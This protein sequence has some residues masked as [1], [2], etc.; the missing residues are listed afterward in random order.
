MNQNK[1]HYDRFCLKRYFI[2]QNGCHQRKYAVAPSLNFISRPVSWLSRPVKI[3][4]G[5]VD[6]QS[7]QGHL[8]YQ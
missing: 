2:L 1:W 4:L 6:P 5:H 7:V 8:F 3:P